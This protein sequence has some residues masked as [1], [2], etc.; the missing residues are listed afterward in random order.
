[1]CNHKPDNFLAQQTLQ[2]IR[3]KVA[4][5]HFRMLNDEKRNSRFKSAIEYWISKGKQRVMDIGCGT[6]LL[7]IYAANTRGVKKV[8]AIE[9]DDVM[10]SIASKVFSENQLNSVV[11]IN[12]Y[13]T[14]LSVPEDIPERVDLI[15]SEILDCGAFGEGILSSLIHAKENFLSDNGKIVP[16][17][18][19][20]FVS[21][22]TSTELCANQVTINSSF[23]NYIYTGNLRLVSDNEE[24]Y[25]AEYIDQ[26]SD[27]KIITNTCETL[28]VDFNSMRSMEG[29]LDGSIEK[30]FLLRSN[31]NNEYLDGFVVWFDLYLNQD[32][33]DC[34]ISTHPS[35]GASNLK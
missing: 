9:A 15:V 2:N 23:H 17:K 1:V 18:V 26:I 12:E 10:H 33:P 31:T 5:W 22:Y 7:S 25:D 16:W 28:E 24:P 4:R 8:Y 27:F 30:K 11:L 14:S 13:S 35:E 3:S 32:D 19:K 20:I 6:G 21:G 29:H 34:K